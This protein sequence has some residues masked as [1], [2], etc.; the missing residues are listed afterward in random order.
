MLEHSG[1]ILYMTDRYKVSQGYEP[2][3]TKMLNA[4]GIR[5]N[6]VV[7]ADIY[8]LVSN[9]LHRVGNEKIWRFVPDK[10]PEIRQAFAQRVRVIRP[11]VIVVSCPAVIGV[12]VNGDSRLGTL[13]KMRGGVYEFEGIPVVVTYPITAIHQR[14]DDRLVSG[15]DEANTHEPYKVPMG[16]WILQRDWQKAGR[17]FHDRQRRLPKFVYSVCRTLNDLFAARDWLKD[18]RL[19]ATDIET[20]GFPAYIT[21]VGYCGLHRDGTV[22]SF[23][24]PFSDQFKERGVYWDSEDDH[25]IAES[26]MR[27]I[28][29]LPILK[30]MQNGQYDCS[31]FVKYGSP[32]QDYLIDTMLMWYALY[33]EAPKSLDFISSILLD[34]FQYWKDDIKGVENEKTGANQRREA[35]L[36]KYW[37][38]NALDCYNTLWNAYYLLQLLHV[39]SNTAMRINYNDVFMRSLSGFGMSMRGVKAD[40]KRRDEIRAQL[41]SERDIALAKFR[42]ILCEPHFNINSPDQ[43]K[44]LLY[45]L[46]GLPLRNAKGRFVDRNKPK[47]GPNAPSAGAIPLKMAKTEHPFFKYVIERMEDAMVPDKQISNVCDMK[48]FTDRFRTCYQ[49]AGTETTR[50]SSKGS[51]FWDGG[52]A[53]NIRGTYRDWL[54]ADDG[55]ILFDVDYS[56]SDDVFVAF[57]SNDPGKIAL[58]NSDMDGHAVHG[59]LF[60]KRDYDWIVKGKKAN[61][62][63]VV[64][65]IYGI[66]Q[67]SKKIVHGTNFQMAAMTLFIQMGRESVV[68]AARLIGIKDA[69]RLTQDQLLQVCGSLMAAYR[70]K[71]PRLSRKEW[72]AEI[73]KQLKE[74]GTI[75]NA[76]GIT[77]RFLG[78]PAD[79]GT[80]REATAYIGQSGT[81]GNMNRSMYEIDLG[82]IPERFRDGL[83]PDRHA[84]P[85]KMNA[86]SHGIKLQLQSHDSFTFGLNTRHPKWKE[87]AHNV[88]HVMGRPT[89]I[90]GHEVRVKTEAEVGFRWGKNMTFWD[91]KDP[92]D[93]DRIHASLKW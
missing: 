23:V 60:F 77:R 72:Y 22:R 40:F 30:A 41:E 81:S 67:L 54:V 63:D 5:R 39:E 52:N 75:V 47:K 86:E 18:C 38:Y 83:N 69:E 19:I 78:N 8:G 34:N 58:A 21:C 93:L 1:K 17:F 64:H 7:T 4:S 85:L 35:N 49:A 53:Q 73:A 24:I 46:F 27:E 28:N 26:V 79:N 44:S 51:N 25:L 37:R 10:L 91:G 50:F 61:D 90:N 57:E 89:I 59:E 56:Q 20:G 70:K 32:T 66:R 12:L 55:W 43:K 42:W 45:D 29:A 16:A 84:K 74:T 76:Y 13:E 6:Q 36:E 33:M 68:A 87:A 92:Y 62:P 88:L 15:V 80:Q 9:T 82:Y 11:K 31:Y 65:P 3:F 2:A 71:Y 14:T 48:L